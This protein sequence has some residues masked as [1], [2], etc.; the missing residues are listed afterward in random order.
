MIWCGNNHTTIIDIQ[1]KNLASCM[2]WGDNNR[3]T[4]ILIQKEFCKLYDMG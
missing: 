3:T 2:I 4:I 1:K